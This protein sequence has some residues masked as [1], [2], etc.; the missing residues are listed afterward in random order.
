MKAKIDFSS[1]LNLAIED[2]KSSQ[3]VLTHA[4]ER[5]SGKKIEHEEK[6]LPH[7]LQYELARST[8][9]LNKIQNIYQIE[10]GCYPFNLASV[11]LSDFLADQVLKSEPYVRNRGVQIT[12]ECA[13]D[14][15]GFFDEALVDNVMATV[16]A[17][18]VRYSKSQ[19][20]LR[21]FIGKNGFLE[22]HIED[23]GR[24][25]PAH[26]VCDNVGKEWDSSRFSEAGRFGTMI[27]YAARVATFHQN[28]GK[29]GFISL[30]NG[31]LLGGGVF[32]LCLP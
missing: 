13:E 18:S 6:L 20:L 3:G 28:D 22:C 11:E 17:N 32:S 21:A 24:G 25:Y 5:F 12:V 23:D 26:V 19:V 4:L 31:G 2:I 1:I 14:L 30:A 15:T 10:T 7:D 16:L 29:K 8:G 9:N 27:F